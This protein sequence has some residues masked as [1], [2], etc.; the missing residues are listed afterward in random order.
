MRMLSVHYLPSRSLSTE[1]RARRDIC[2]GRAN[3]AHNR[4]RERGRTGRLSGHRLGC[5]GAVFPAPLR[6]CGRDNRCGQP[7]PVWRG[8]PPWL[9]K[10]RPRTSRGPRAG[11]DLTFTERHA[12][13]P[14]A[15]W[16]GGGTGPS[17]RDGDGRGALRGGRGAL[18]GGAAGNGGAGVE[19]GGGD[20]GHRAGECS[21][22]SG[23]SG[24][25]AG[26]RSEQKS[27]EE[28]QEECGRAQPGYDAEAAQTSVEA[29]EAL[30]LELSS[31]KVRTNR[32]FCR[33]KHKLRQAFKPHLERRSNIIERIRGFWFKTILNHPLMS[34]MISDQDQDMLNYMIS[35]K[36]EEFIHPTNS[37]KIIFFFG[38]NPY[39]QNEVITKEYDITI[40]GY[41]ASHSTPI[42]WL[43][44]YECQTNSYSNSNT[45]LNFF[46][47]LSDHNFAG[48]NRIAE[49]ICED[50]WL[51]P[52]Q[53]YLRI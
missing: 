35:L 32:A 5:Q 52:L 51:N 41:K 45:S 4:K 22:G 18:G 13:S 44:D 33:L 6:F 27:L 26:A 39:F 12:R 3:G 14:P 46:N 29:L 21:G 7:D 10:F 25:R 48:S 42:Q 30:Q 8:L 37:C 34:A 15:C 38:R 49:I 28:G 16:R 17:W 50:L 31:V 2:V 9:R 11:P 53:Y 23:G 1:K 24:R 47:W 19:S 40:T 36:V 43:G 20:G